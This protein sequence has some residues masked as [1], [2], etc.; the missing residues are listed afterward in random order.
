MG[1]V[2]CAETRGTGESVDDCTALPVRGCP[3]IGD[4]AL[5]DKSCARWAHLPDTDYR[6]PRE[7]WLDG[8]SLHPIVDDDGQGESQRCHGRVALYLFN[9]FLVNPTASRVEIALFG[10]T[11]VSWRT[12]MS[13]STNAEGELTATAGTGTE[14]LWMSS[15]SNREGKAPIRGGIPL[16]F[17]QVGSRRMAARMR[18]WLGLRV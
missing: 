5:F 11:V 1:S 6:E 3:P 12:G 18:D 2:F 9:P 14:R 17:P 16:A 13:C 15:L 7:V 4:R 10:A 8:T